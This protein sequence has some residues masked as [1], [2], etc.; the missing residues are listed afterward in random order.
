MQSTTPEPP[1]VREPR[2]GTDGL[3][4]GAVPIVVINDHAVGSAGDIDTLVDRVRTALQTGDFL[5]GV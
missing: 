1:R 4:G 3:N 2:T 5:M